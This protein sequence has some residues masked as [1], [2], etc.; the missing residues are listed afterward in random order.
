M[1][2]VKLEI[3]AAKKLK[4]IADKR[5]HMSVKDQIAYLKS[6]LEPEDP[7]SKLA[8]SD[9]KHFDKYQD[10]ALDGRLDLGLSKQLIEEY[11]WEPKEADVS[12]D[13]SAKDAKK[14]LKVS[15][16]P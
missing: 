12:A 2:Q 11:N 5:K 1:T 10:S 7:R 8:R 9:F 14:M 16:K 15:K 6:E 4:N 3:L 13:L